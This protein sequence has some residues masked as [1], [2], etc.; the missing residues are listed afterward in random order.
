MNGNINKLPLPYIGMF[1]LDLIYQ[2]SDTELLY[3]II[4]K[5]NDVIQSQNNLV[6]N[7]SNNLEEYVNTKLDGWL[8]DGTL[9]S[10]LDN[11]YVVCIGDSYLVGTSANNTI[12]SWG[13]YLCDYMG[14]TQ[15]ENFFMYGSGGSGFYANRGESGERFIDILTT[16]EDKF[17]KSKVTKLIV[18]GGFNDASY[19]YSDVITY[20]QS[21][22]SYANLNYPNA[23]IYIGFMGWDCRYGALSSTNRYNFSINTLY[24]YMSASRFG[25]NVVCVNNLSNVLKQRQYM[26]T[27]GYHPNQNG[28]IGLAMTLYN[29]MNGNYQY[30]SLLQTDNYKYGVLGNVYNGSGS[31]LIKGNNILIRLNQVTI[32]LDDTS[33]I[34]INTLEN[35]ITNTQN[36]ASTGSVNIK[37]QFIMNDNSTEIL[38]CS[39][40]SDENNTS[41][42]VPKKME[43]VKQIIILPQYILCSD[44]QTLLLEI[45]EDN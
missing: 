1:D 32:T 21:F 12:K 8:D 16:N 35:F 5:V 30:N 27:D 3:Q 26:S 34:D 22:I 19:D 7:F 43:N 33:T 41:L 4:S 11:E 23:K 29:A 15:N 10:L 38:T 13:G 2:T 39:L 9:Q 6:D 45:T 44:F 36:S 42:T 37:L 25:K 14:L 28:Y 24:A 31:T 20:I 18:C 17:D 40:V